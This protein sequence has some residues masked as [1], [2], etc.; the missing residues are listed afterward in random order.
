[1]FRRPVGTKGERQEAYRRE[2]PIQALRQEVK[3]EEKADLY[4]GISLGK[5]ERSTLTA[6]GP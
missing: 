2:K 6:W 3:K 5:R 4:P 1:V